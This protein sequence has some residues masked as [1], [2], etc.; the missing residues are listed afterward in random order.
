MAICTNCGSETWTVI[1]RVGALETWRCESCGHEETV[2]VYAP[3]FD[4]VLPQDLEPVFSLVA[5]WKVKPTAR[6]I[7]ALQS[8]F[9]RVRTMS[10]VELMRKARDHEKL[11]LGR[12]TESELQP[13]VPQLESL[14]VELERIP[15]AVS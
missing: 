10:A 14:G 4:P 9:P 13:L 6:D 12:F 2:H 3:Q 11:D 5:R 7:T 15:I 1:A 8:I